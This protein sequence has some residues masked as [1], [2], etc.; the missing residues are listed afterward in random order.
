MRTIES[1]RGLIESLAFFV[2]VPEFAR[3]GRTVPES[4]QNHCG[5]FKPI[6]VT[7]CL[8]KS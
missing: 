1:M 4:N 2:T 7:N 5:L 3:I 8:A 6:R